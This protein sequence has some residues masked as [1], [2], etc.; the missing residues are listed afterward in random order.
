MSLSAFV[1]WQFAKYFRDTVMVLLSNIYCINFVVQESSAQ[2]A[3]GEAFGG[4][5]PNE[6]V[7]NAFNCRILMRI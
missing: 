2:L 7:R 6:K 3:M 1:S 5:P 4:L